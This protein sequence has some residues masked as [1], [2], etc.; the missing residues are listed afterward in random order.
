MPELSSHYIGSLYRCLLFFRVLFIPILFQ[1]LGSSGWQRAHLKQWTTWWR[2]RSVVKSEGCPWYPWQQKTGQL[3]KF[4]EA[5][6]DGRGEKITIANRGSPSTFCPH[7]PQCLDGFIA[8]EV[9]T[10]WY[11]APAGD[12]TGCHW[13]MKGL[14]EQ[15]NRHTESSEPK[16]R[17]F[18]WETQLIWKEEISFP[19]LLSFSGIAL[20]EQSP[21]DASEMSSPASS[22]CIHCTPKHLSCLRKQAPENAA[23]AKPQV[24]L[25]FFPYSLVLLCLTSYSMKHN[26]TYAI[27][28]L[29]TPRLYRLM[30][31][32]LHGNLS[33]GTKGRFWKQWKDKTQFYPKERLLSLCHQSLVLQWH[34]IKVNHPV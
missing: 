26:L 14:E 6:Q 28:A 4:S 18:Q 23:P 2:W 8:K 17:S 11:L 10:F 5:C 22:K 3:V 15:Q 9:F 1:I 27:A 16:E 32:L 13:A 24:V 34:W 12:W 19:L 21:R 31:I 25:S 29:M 30:I 20:A 7:K 33:F